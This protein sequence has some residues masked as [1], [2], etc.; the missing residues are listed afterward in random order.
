MSNCMCNDCVGP[1]VGNIRDEEVEKDLKP[2]I[3]EVESQNINI[4]IV[5]ECSTC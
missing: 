5:G 1:C 2:L 3:E 4:G